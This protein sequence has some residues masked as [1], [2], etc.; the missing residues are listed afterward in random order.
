[1]Q[2]LISLSRVRALALVMGLAAPA[3][4]GQIPPGVPANN[5]GG[6]QAPLPSGATPQPGFPAAAMLA[7]EPMRDTTSKRHAD[8]PAVTIMEFR[9]NVQE[10]APRAATDMFM[11]ALVET[12]R[13]RV[14][15]R[16]RMNEGINQEKALNQQGLVGGSA[17]AVRAVA[18]KYIFEGT[19]SEA[20]MDQNAQSVG[21][22]ILG[23][24]GKR[25]TTRDTIGI[26]VRIIEVDSGIVADAIKVRKQLKGSSTSVGGI[27]DAITNNLSQ[28]F[29]G[30]AIQSFGNKEYEAVQKE[31]LDNALRQAIEE[32]VQRI[33]TRFAD[34]S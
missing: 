9:S 15:E 22:N 17:S 12:G 10:V 4:F 30:G 18:A 23:I 32:A 31:S 24:G 6:T 25:T 8:R 20:Q 29:L 11:T 33:A 26:D 28:Q 14:L 2:H 13:F 27:G 1:M 3:A 34:E 19:V 5:A 21:L 16:A 7:P